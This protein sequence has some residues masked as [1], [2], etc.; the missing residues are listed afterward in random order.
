MAWRAILGAVAVLVWVATAAVAETRIALVVGIGG[1]AA[2]E[3]LEN[4]VADATAMAAA[5]EARGFRVTLVTEADKDALARAMAQFGRDLRFAGEAATGLFYYA[6]HGVQSFGTNYLVPADAVLTDAADLP[7]VAVPADSILRQMASARN[8]T[9]IVILDACRDNPFV[10]VPDM[11][12]T[13]LAEMKAPT[14][15]FLA[16]STA[17]G[18]VA[19]DGTDGN[20]PFTRALLREMQVPGLPI[21]QVFRQTRVAVI[22][23]TGGLQTPWDTSSL[24]GEFVFT[25]ADKPAPQ[26][27]AAAQLWASVKATRD[28]VQILLFLRAYPNSAHDTEARA[29][30]TELMRTELERAA[31][32]GTADAPQASGT[33]PSETAAAQAPASTAPVEPDQRE[34]DLIERARQSG[35]AAD[36]EAYLAAYPQGV[37]AELAGYELA[38]LRE[39]AAAEDGA[40]APPAEAEG[41]GQPTGQQAAGAAAAA[42]LPDRVLF[43][44]PLPAGM[45]EIGGRSLADLIGGSPLYPPVE[46]IPDALWKGQTCANCHAWTRQALCTQAGTYRSAEA[47]RA[48]AKPHPYGTPFKQAL[49]N[50]ALGGCE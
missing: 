30:L 13:G 47:S 23:A 46:G 29:L 19:L 10:S 12:D 15:T 28:P 1:Y 8:R 18:A 50:W 22:E 7:L 36:Y 48:L 11:N 42:G 14:G 31:Q 32:G 45:G 3:P 44:M 33:G 4:A 27:L 24:T 21:E 35:L 9:N 37:Y 34:R 2:V 5:L 41:A 38:I 26:D 17:P 40:Q 20:S 39:T 6:G 25:P 43:D 16:Y 49:R